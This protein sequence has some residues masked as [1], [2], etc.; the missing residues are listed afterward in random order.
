MLHL[1]G[2][3]VSNVDDSG[4]C[5]ALSWDHMTSSSV[6][7]TLSPP[8]QSP[9]D[10]SLGR[11]EYVSFTVTHAAAA[12]LLACLSLSGFYRLARLFGTLEWLINYKRRQRFAAALQRVLGHR[13]TTKERRRAT[14]E[15][16]VRNRC[17]KLLYLIFD[18]IAR[19]RATAL[20]SI[21]NQTLLDD[22]LARGRGV[23]VALSHHGAHHV[24]A[25][26]MALRGYKAAG[27]RDR[28]EG[29]L[30]RYVQQLFDR[31]YPEFPRLRVLFAD[32]YPRDVYR[33]LQDGYVLG[34]L[35]D[36][37]RVRTAHQKTES[38]TIFGEKRSFLSGPLRI[39]IRCRTPVLQ[40]FIMP[41]TNFRY[42]LEI[43]ETLVDPDKVSDE[44][45]AVGQ[46]MRRYAAN[47]EKYVRASPSLLSR[48]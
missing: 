15:F 40:A 21:G 45:A 9:H 36:I 19:N 37:G 29:A 32:A 44:E 14:R 48:L 39:A 34:S 28:K 3:L 6:A 25:M 46:A 18:R 30:R 20:L 31:R 2:W 13:P 10:G 41:D 22:A 26:L 27:V 23:Y 4:L 8:A 11:W 33:C 43:V 24:I 47:V 1:D 35:L 42:R 17:D 38:V 16:F 7:S 12:C 5:S